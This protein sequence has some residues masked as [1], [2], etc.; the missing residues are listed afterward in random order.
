MRAC[1]DYAIT[2]QFY[3][4]IQ[5][6]KFIEVGY[7]FLMAASGMLLWVQVSWERGGVRGNTAVTRTLPGSSGDTGIRCGQNMV[8]VDTQL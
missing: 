1:N 3:E 6:T 5:Q 7:V 8:S 2:M 4:P